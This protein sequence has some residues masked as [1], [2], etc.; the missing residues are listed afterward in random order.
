MGLR[1]SIS[2]W[3]IYLDCYWVGSLDFNCLE[4]QGV[5]AEVPLIKRW[6]FS[7]LPPLNPFDRRFL[8]QAQLP[9]NSLP[10][11]VFLLFGIPLFSTHQAKNKMLEFR[12]PAKS[13]ACF[14][15]RTCS[16][17]TG[18]VLK[19]RQISCSDH[20]PGIHL[21]SMANLPADV[22]NNW[23]ALTHVYILEPDK[24][25]HSGCGSPGIFFAFG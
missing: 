16:L 6:R 18:T 22:L 24:P 19:A 21:K 5:S 3:A 17:M 10:F 2:G 13:S 14:N 7:G 4:F 15:G 11:L 23:L 25:V 8:A 20:S 12:I 9:Q 1:A